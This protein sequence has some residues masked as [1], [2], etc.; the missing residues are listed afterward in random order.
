[1]SYYIRPATSHDVD[2][3]MRL[4]TEAEV[5]LRSIGSDQWTDTEMGARA[6]DRWMST[7]REER[8]WVIDD[9]STGTVAATVS[10][11]PADSDFWGPEDHPELALYIYKLIVSRS[12]AGTGLGDRI[13]DW[14]CDVAAAEGR[15]FVRIDCWRT[16]T[17]LQRYYLQRG[18]S[19]VRT[20]SPSHRKSGWLA[21]RPAKRNQTHR[22]TAPMEN[23]SYASAS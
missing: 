13:L 3:L 8:T 20:E 12:A 6:I 19:H 16:A 2:N 15:P 1:M 18:F 10:R 7:I 14:A 4:R 17:K 11:G 22:L 9:L 5:W 23:S 21:Q